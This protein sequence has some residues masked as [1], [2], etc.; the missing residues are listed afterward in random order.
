MLPSPILEQ[1]QQCDSLSSIHTCIL[2]TLKIHDGWPLGLV[3]H[4]G[5]EP[6]LDERAAR[7]HGGCQIR[8]GAHVLIVV[9]VGHDVPIPDQLQTW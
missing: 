2:C 8:A 4:L 6:G 7:E 9:C 3:N 5:K 1:E